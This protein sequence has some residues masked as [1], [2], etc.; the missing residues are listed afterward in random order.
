MTGRSAAKNPT[1]PETP[2]SETIRAPGKQEVLRDL[3]AR[4]EGASLAELQAASG[5]QA[6]S[7]RAAISGLRK[8]GLGIVSE[9]TDGGLRRYRLTAG[10]RDG[11]GNAGA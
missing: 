8:R 9:Q 4:P 1:H 2:A 5:W 10:R 3:L 7:V 11:S 6:H